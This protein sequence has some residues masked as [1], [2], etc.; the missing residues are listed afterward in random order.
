MPSEKL[1]N[2]L[3]PLASRS[4]REREIGSVKARN[5]D[6]CPLDRELS[7]DV[8]PRRAI[9]GRGEGDHGDLGEV[10]FELTELAVFAPKLMP[11]R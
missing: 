5:K 10:G 9:S 2:L 6:S 4:Y 7:E 8:S 1:I 3:K 11:P